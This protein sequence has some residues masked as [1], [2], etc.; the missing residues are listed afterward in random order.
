MKSRPS[1]EF[2]NLILQFIEEE[3]GIRPAERFEDSTSWTVDDQM[4]VHKAVAITCIMFDRMDFAQAFMSA[5]TQYTEHTIAITLVKLAHN[6]TDRHR[7]PGKL[8][9]TLCERHKQ[10]LVN[11]WQYFVAT[12]R[13]FYTEGARKEI[14]TFCEVQ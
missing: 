14:F 10:A 3:T 8:H 7:L 12:V 11:V 4:D 13:E 2:V 6:K 1:S 9:W 5:G